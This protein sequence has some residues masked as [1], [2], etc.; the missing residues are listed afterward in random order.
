M[1]TQKGFTLI[2]LLLVLAIIGIISAIAIPALLGQRSRARDKS[3]VSNLVGMV[4]DGV[5]Q[6]DKKKEAG[7]TTANILTAIQTYMTANHGSDKNPWDANTPAYAATI[8]V[9]AGN[10][11]Q[12]A[13]LTA[14][15]TPTALGQVQMY[16][17]H[18]NSTVGGFVGGIVKV[19]NTINGQ[20]TV[21][22]A[23]AIE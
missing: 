14:M 10:A 4:D 3:A 6:Y 2:E 22:K 20:T 23:S 21:R 8:S 5:G 17:Q 16:V 15:T 9:L 7:S 18:P 13:F 12:S 1:K 11:T 19:Q